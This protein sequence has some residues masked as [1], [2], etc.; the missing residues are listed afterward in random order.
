MQ[1]TNS[2]SNALLK[3][4]LTSCSLSKH[5]PSAD[6]PFIKNSS[7]KKTS[8]RTLGELANTVAY[9]LPITCDKALEEGIIEPNV[10]EQCRPRLVTPETGPVQPHGA[11]Y[12]ASNHDTETT[13]GSVLTVIPSEGFA[14]T[15]P[16]DQISQSYWS[17]YAVASQ[18]DTQQDYSQ[19]PGYAFTTNATQSGIQQDN[20]QWLGYA[21]PN[22]ASHSETQQDYSQ[23]PGYA[24]PPNASQSENQQE[25]PQWPEY[26]IPNNGGQSETEPNYSLWPG[27]AIYGGSNPAETQQEIS[28]PTYVSSTPAIDYTYFTTVPYDSSTT[29]TTAIPLTSMGRPVGP[30][31]NTLN[32]QYPVG[33]QERTRRPYTIG[34][35]GTC[36][37]LLRHPFDS[38]PGNF[39]C[40]CHGSV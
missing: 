30:S 16:S 34:K 8:K 35:F 23:W 18:P 36:E 33:Y 37:L 3:N 22:N 7:H 40:I 38:L 39:S 12:P 19:W 28:S 26:A 15:S 10:V 13:V 25:Y 4:D 27:Y 11:T 32:G 29:P 24:I 5:L 1:A 20:S 17:G 2:C 21:F 9:S 6:V 14:V 31:Y